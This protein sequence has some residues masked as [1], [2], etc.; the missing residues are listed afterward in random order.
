MRTRWMLVFLSVF[1]V[2]CR[3]GTTV[4]TMVV[5][6]PPATPTINAAATATRGR[7]CPTRHRACSHPSGHHDPPDNRRVTPTMLPATRRVARPTP[8]PGSLKVVAQGYGQ[9]ARRIG[10]AFI[11]Q[12]ADPNTAVDFSPFRVSAFDAAGEVLSVNTGHCRRL[13][14]PMARRG[15]GTLSATE[16]PYRQR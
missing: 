2:G 8:P 5:T 14:R 16:Y 9:N 15:R 10:Y 1:L 3:S 4:V 6:N 12:N 7:T 11:V 13:F